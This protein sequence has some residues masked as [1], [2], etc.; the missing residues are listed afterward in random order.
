MKYVKNQKQRGIDK[1]RRRFLDM[2]G[3]TGISSAILRSSPLV[4]GALS[5][6]Y[7][8]AASGAGKRM[9]FMYLPDGSPPGHWLPSSVSNMNT[10]TAPYGSGAPGIQGY[11]I[12][13]YCKFYEVNNSWNEH[14]QTFKCM[15]NRSFHA[16]Q[17]MN[18]LDTQIAKKNFFPSQFD[19]VRVGV[20]KQAVGFSI[21]G[22]EAASFINGPTKAYNDIFNGVKV[23]SNDKTYEKVF[24]MNAAAI[25]SIKNKLG[26]DERER[27]TVHLEAME[28]IENDLMKA[29]E[30]DSSPEACEANPPGQGGEFIEECMQVCDV[31]IAALKCGLTNVASIMLSDNQAE[32]EIPAETRALMNLPVGTPQTYHSSNHS[33]GQIGLKGLGQFLSVISQVPAYFIYKLST[34]TAPGESAPLIDSTLFCQICDMGYGDHTAGG[35][36][37]ILASNSSEFG[38]GGFSNRG[39]GT[40]T[41]LLESIPG[42]LGLDGALTGPI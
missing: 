15:G 40:N 24:A 34:E 26:S 36:P 13:K 35:A 11:D 38:M 19:I 29:A 17:Y 27:L 8:Q 41:Q 39:Y 5:T 23:N 3:R 28:K 32:W 9:V 18:T 4:M 21:E 31:V 30:G 14:G 12:A 37:W 7:A 22:G 20:R 2:V 6:R 42:R 1:E 10:A 33:I 16:G 25:D